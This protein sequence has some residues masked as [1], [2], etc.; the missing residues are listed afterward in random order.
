M[1]NKIKVK[2]AIQKLHKE[3][4]STLPNPDTAIMELME[5][6]LD[7]NETGIIQSLNEEL[8]DE[9]KKTLE[10]IIKRMKK[11]EPIEYITGLSHFY[12]HRFKVDTS[13]LIPR[14]E[15]EML[16]AMT[17]EKI[18]EKL[19]AKERDDI[20][21]VDIGTGS[22]CII[23]SLAAALQGKINFFATEFNKKAMKIAKEN[24]EAYDL[25]DT[26]KTKVGDLLEPLHEDI[27]FDVIVANLPYIPEKDMDTLPKSVQQYE[28]PQALKGGK[29][30]HE[31]IER[32]LKQ[33]GSRLN[34]SGVILLEAQ[35]KIM[36]KIENRA[37]EIYPQANIK[38]TK[39]VFDKDRF[40]TIQT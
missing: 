39:D 33:A 29:N 12:G 6:L 31:I 25:K 28:P 35:P 30:G 24:I 4:A 21:V 18:Y 2:E 23:I 15:T 13:T 37:Q 40:L 27:N 36:N 19:Y 1:S 20:N 34:D 16:V 7:T 8:E 14:V 3:F 26:I 9:Q 17:S 22:G 11:E 32:L 5:S 38:V 10:L